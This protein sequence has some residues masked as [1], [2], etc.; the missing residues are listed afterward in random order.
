VVYLAGSQCANGRCIP[1][2][3]HSILEFVYADTQISLKFSFANVGRVVSD[4]DQQQVVEVINKGSAPILATAFSEPFQVFSAKKFPGVI[5][6]TALSKC[7]AMQGIKI[8]IRKD[9]VR[10]QGSRGRHSDEDDGLDNEF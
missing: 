5:E 4:L 10:G 2:R 8:P 1:V 7:F 3:F 6:S 9:G